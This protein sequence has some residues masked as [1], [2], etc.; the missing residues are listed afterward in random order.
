M[1]VEFN[2][3]HIYSHS[4]IS[5]VLRPMTLKLYCVLVYRDFPILLVIYIVS[6]GVSVRPVEFSLNI[7]CLPKSNEEYFTG[8]G[9][10][11]HGAIE[12]MHQMLCR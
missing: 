12:M 10:S 6:L 7:I 9:S 8:N 3:P 5:I 1:Y 2:V 4:N 11:S